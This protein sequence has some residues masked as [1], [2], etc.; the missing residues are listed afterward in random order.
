[1]CT[2][3]PHNAK[4]NQFRYI[5][6]NPMCKQISQS[7]L[8]KFSSYFAKL[9][10]SYE[11]SYLEK[12]WNIRIRKN[13]YWLDI[14][15]VIISDYIEVSIQGITYN[16]MHMYEYWIIMGFVWTWF[17]MHCKIYSAWFKKEIETHFTI[18][19]SKKIQSWIQ[20]EFFWTCFIKY[21]KLYRF[22][23]EMEN[24]FSVHIFYI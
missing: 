20:I 19:I 12:K 9:L 15:L 16:N 17:I 13:C 21:C 10:S 2:Y 22:K 14:F 4:H 3:C 6:L 7:V 1:M 8:E 11:K 5:W 24:H 23:K 18:S